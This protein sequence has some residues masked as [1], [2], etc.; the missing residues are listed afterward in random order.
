MRNATQV[1]V[2][3]TITRQ[4]VNGHTFDY[5]V[6]GHRAD[7]S[8]IVRQWNAVHSEACTCATWEGSDRSIPDW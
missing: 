2:G 4:A 1:Q 8:P 3:D 5:E 6:I 7:G